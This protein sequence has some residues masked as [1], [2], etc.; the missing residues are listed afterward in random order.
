MKPRYRLTGNFTWKEDHTGEWYK[1]IDVDTLLAAKDAQLDE[2]RNAIS[3]HV[4]FA[5]VLTVKDAE[6]ERIQKELAGWE[7]WIKEVLTDF[8]IPYDDHKSSWRVSLVI[9]MASKDSRI[10]ELEAE[11][12]QQKDECER[13]HKP[14]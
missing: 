1:A 3:G 9:R 11:I 4:S 14:A 2:L 5:D 8:R 13:F 12:R 10:A 6:I 7:R